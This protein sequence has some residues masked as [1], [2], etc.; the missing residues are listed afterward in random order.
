LLPLPFRHRVAALG[1][2][3]DSEVSYRAI[4]EIRQ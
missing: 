3:S 4:S 1:N 2:R